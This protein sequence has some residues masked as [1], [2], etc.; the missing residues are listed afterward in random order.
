MQDTKT[1]TTAAL[2]QVVPDRYV[3]CDVHKDT[4]TV[5]VADTG[6]TDSMVVATIPNT[7]A[8]V[9]QMLAR[10]EHGG[11]LQV[12]YEAGPCGYTLH[13]QLTALGIDCQVAAPT[14]I[15]IR[16]G[17]RIKTDRR[18]ALRLAQLARSGLLTAVTVP[19]EA[20][21]DL[22]DLVR[23]RRQAR[24]DRHR[25]Q[26]RIGKQLLRLGIRYPG[27][28]KPW[29]LAHR[30]WLA[31]LEVA[32]AGQQQV[33]VE[34]LGALAEAEGRLAR[35]ETAMIEQAAESA[36]ADLVTAYQSLR[37]IEQVSAVTLVAELGDLSRFGSPREAMAYLGLVPSEHSSGGNRKQGGITKTGNAAARHVLVE[38]A[39]HYRHAPRV[40]V[41]LATRQ[42]QVCG[43]ICAISWKAQHRLHRR[44][45]RLQQRGKPYAVAVTAVAR[46]LVGF[47]WAIAQQVAQARAGATALPVQAV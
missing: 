32:G 33:L 28:G 27:P 31:R 26:Q 12:W 39:H 37:G 21:E 13:R 4:I 17:D 45:W 24:D 18:D 46:E 35:L 47:L 15:P 1:H 6:Q 25:Q 19:D 16:R 29:T 9:R 34:L 8:A 22:R 23:A 7:P 11:V 36:L 40:S 42:R 10:L 5:A 20:S 44:F 41:A 14:L 30:T 2:E 3:G 43:P 38:A